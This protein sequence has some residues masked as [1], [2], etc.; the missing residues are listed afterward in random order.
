M[1]DY[2]F[3][4]PEGARQKST[5]IGFGGEIHS[6][7][8]ADGTPMYFPGPNEQEFQMWFDKNDSHDASASE[9]NCDNVEAK[10]ADDPCTEGYEQYGMKMKNGVSSRTYTKRR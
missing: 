8:M 6:D 2:I 1:E 7:Q 3:S 9:C 5:E 4:T 10:D